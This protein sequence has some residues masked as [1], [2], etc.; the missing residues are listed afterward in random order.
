MGEILQLLFPERCVGCGHAHAL[1]CKR[2]SREWGYPITNTIEDVPLI[3]S[4]FYS[5]SISHIVLKAKENNDRRCRR[6]LANAIASH[7]SETETLIP[8]PSSPSSIRR[9]GFDHALLLA[10]EV[11]RLTGSSLWHGLRVNRKIQDQTKLNHSA[12]FANLSG[13][14]SFLSVNSGNELPPNVVVIDDLVTT[15]ASM[16]EA[17]RV[18]RSEKGAEMRPIKAISACIASHHLPNTI[19]P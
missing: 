7:I 14:Y 6:I 4:A 8:I 1:L 15:G 13:A 3:S 10:E 5:E 19:S 9:R 17:I 18:L 11:A 16:R 12:R 2:C